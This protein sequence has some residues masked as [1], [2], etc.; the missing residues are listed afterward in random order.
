MAVSELERDWLRVVELVLLRVV[1]AEPCSEDVVVGVTVMLVIAV[2]VC[3]ALCEPVP[4]CE[5]LTVCVAV[6]SG[7]ALPVGVGVRL[8]VED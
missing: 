8:D 3:E 1:V 2:V 5:E 6:A 7:K 4:P